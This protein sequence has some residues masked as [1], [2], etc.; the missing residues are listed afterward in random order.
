MAFI[1][2]TKIENGGGAAASGS[3]GTPGAGNALLHAGAGSTNSATTLVVTDGHN[4][5]TT[6]GGA[7]PVAGSALAMA[8]ASTPNVT[9]VATS[10]TCTWNSSTFVGFTSFIYEFSGVP[11]SS[12]FDV[13]GTQNVGTGTAVATAALLNTN[14]NDVFLGVF[15][16]NS[17]ANPSA[18]SSTGSG[19]T[20]PVGGSETNGSAFLVAGS[21]YKTVATN[22]S[23]TETWT[24][25]ND[26]WAARAAAYR[27]NAA[28]GGGTGPPN[29]RR[30]MGVG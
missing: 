7:I 8:F 17:G 11:T 3:V 25:T 27:T 9:A 23:E 12:L 26:Q 5:W 22:A 1:A 20:L 28:A 2:V 18:I 10:V 14:T 30:L 4:T 21:G 6:D 19:W 15:G 13:A 16:N 29:R 24:D